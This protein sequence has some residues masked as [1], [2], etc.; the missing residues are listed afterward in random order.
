M[1]ASNP[2]KRAVNATK[3][4]SIGRPAHSAVAENSLTSP[5]PHEA[6]TKQHRTGD[7]HQGACAQLACPIDSSGVR[8]SR[9]EE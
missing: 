5:P 2:P 1:S 4:S 9:R 6:E 3:G 7:E 8:D